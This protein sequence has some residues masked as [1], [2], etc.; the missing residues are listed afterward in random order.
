MIFEPD[1]KLKQK[2][3]KNGSVLQYMYSVSGAGK[4]LFAMGV[5][6][7]G[8]GIILTALLFN[9]MEPQG[10]ITFGAVIV[11]LGI[12]SAGLGIS[13][14]K[15]K[16]LGWAE[17][18]RK[19]CG[20]SEQELHQI[21]QEFRQPGTVL[22]SMDKGKDT[23]SLKRMGFITA[24]YVKFPSM[25]PCVFR[26]ED[27][28]ACLYTKKY[29]CQDGGYDRALVAYIADRDLGFLQRNPPE[30][31]SL[32][33]VKAIAEHNPR[34]VT[35]HFFTYEGKDY[36]AVRKPEEVVE[37]HKRLY[38]KSDSDVKDEAAASPKPVPERIAYQPTQK[39]EPKKSGW[40]AY[41]WKR[42][43]ALVILFFVL[44]GI[45]YGP[46]I[47]QRYQ[48]DHGAIATQESQNQP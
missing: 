23:N 29:L 33:I 38:K 16:E 37:L 12:L 39:R 26:L 45:M 5:M 6:L 27:M 14:Q 22:L 44:M 2:M 41:G 42:G 46:K 36:D 28:V 24:N 25:D 10:A 48:M 9:T 1:D 4:G 20:L 34:I 43:V 15:K 11:V 19:T 3:S 35:D 17:A 30:E 32:D 31:A 13:M 18:Y 8:I 47:Y 7:I 21:D 40:E